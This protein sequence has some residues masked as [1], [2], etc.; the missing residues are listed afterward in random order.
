MVLKIKELKF[1]AKE[2][3]MAAGFEGKQKHR[4]NR[5]KYLLK[6]RLRKAKCK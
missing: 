5:K 3:L 6:R 4:L 2:G 1:V